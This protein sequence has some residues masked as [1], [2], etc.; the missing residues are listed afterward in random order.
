MSAALLVRL[1]HGQAQKR[2]VCRQAKIDSLNG[3]ATCIEAWGW[4]GAGAYLGRIWWAL[5]D[6]FVEPMEPT[7]GEGSPTALAAAACLRRC[8]IAAE[9]SPSDPTGG[10]A[11]S[12]Q[13]LMDKV[14]SGL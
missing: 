4:E 14:A 7:A 10:S 12:K 6:E 8:L 2:E 3:L 11:K 13:S 1:H 9:Q 5:R